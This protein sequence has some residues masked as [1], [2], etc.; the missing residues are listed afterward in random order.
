MRS[1]RALAW[2]VLV[3]ACLVAVF[4]DFFSPYPPTSQFRDRPY[5][6]PGRYND[7][8]VH[9]FVRGAPYMWL[10]IVPASLRLVG[11]PE[12][13][14]IFILGTDEFG[15]DWYSRLCHG[16][17]VSLLLAPA[18][19]L[20]S[21][22]LA[23]A[24]GS[25]A[26][27]Q[28]RLVD[29]LVMRASEVFIVL[30]WFYVVIALRAALP[31]TISSSAT[32]FIVFAVL[33]ALGCATPAR[34]FR[35]LVVSLKTREFVLAARTTGAGDAR[36]FRWHVLPFLLPAAWTQFLVSVPVYIVTEVTLSFLGL[37]VAEPTP[38]WG[39]MLVPLQQ[40][41][42]LTSYPWM[43]APAAAVVA[44][45][46]ALHVVARTDPSTTLG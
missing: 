43:F 21:L 45:C 42:V 39:S 32:L 24:L 31:L 14:R 6:E 8:S 46:L 23:L 22:A 9:W 7:A 44:V 4:P 38:T 35:G 28:G 5:A 27:Y 26:G 37:G 3:A 13:G 25:W 36:V 2:A 34:L 40:Y 29:A 10:G 1:V 15:R 11:A 19:A 12:P 16:A 33:A 20:L 17:S 41:V 30:P 18:A